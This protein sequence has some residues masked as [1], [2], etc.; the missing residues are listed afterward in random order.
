M[1]TLLAVFLLQCLLF[2]L[3]Q[4]NLLEDGIGKRIVIEANYSSPMYHLLLKKGDD[5][6][7]YAFI[8]WTCEQTTR[9]I[10]DWSDVNNDGSDYRSIKL[11]ESSGMEGNDYA[12]FYHSP[13]P[14]TSNTSYYS[15][16][17]FAIRRSV[18]QLLVTS[19]ELDATNLL[20]PFPAN[21]HL[22]VMNVGMR[23][24]TAV[25]KVY[26][27]DWVNVTYCPTVTAG[28]S[29]SCE[30]AVSNCVSNG[31]T[32]TW[33][34]LVAGE[35]YSVDLFIKY[36]PS[37]IARHLA[38]C[39]FQTK[40][41][42]VERR[43]LLRSGQSIKG[44][45][46][47]RNLRNAYLISGDVLQIQACNRVELYIEIYNDR[48]ELI[49]RRYVTG[50]DRILGA[51]LVYVYGPPGAIYRL[52]VDSKLPATPKLTIA[53]SVKCEIVRKDNIRLVTVILSWWGKGQTRYCLYVRRKPRRPMHYSLKTFQIENVCRA[54]KSDQWKRMKCWRAKSKKKFLA[55]VNKLTEGVSYDFVVMA[56]RKRRT[57]VS[58]VIT[59]F[60]KSCQ[61]ST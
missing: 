55:L 25:W 1:I 19:S 57:S 35:T 53:R 7:R 29:N 59:V 39:P 5:K 49:A 20:R 46:N 28:R 37:G 32:H 23:S 6:N 34:N 56:T 18:V 27:V 2:S 36:K 33:R 58:N 10:I 11:L 48:S 4:P 43:V 54:P 3:Q 44:Q 22:N 17:F 38:A 50:L 52:G 47:G 21:A 30:F 42:D 60:T 45:M 15:I 24:A 41:K 8:M 12:I 26:N 13:L 40:M 31:N 51:R 14:T 16:R 9:W 61:K